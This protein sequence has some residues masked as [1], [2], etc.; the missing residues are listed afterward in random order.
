MENAN[1]SRRCALHLA[2]KI[3][4]L[5]FEAASVAAAFCLVHEVHKVHHA[6]EKKNEK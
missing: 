3:A 1:H 2:M 4:K 5:A 6:I